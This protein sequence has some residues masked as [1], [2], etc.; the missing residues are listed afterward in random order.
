MQLLSM[1][2]VISV[3]MNNGLSSQAFDKSFIDYQ[4]SQ[5]IPVELAET[6][7]EMQCLHDCISKY[8]TANKS[9]CARSC[10]LGAVGSKK[11]PD[12]GIQYKKCLVDCKKNKACTKRCR[13]ERVKC[14]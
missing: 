11:K 9:S 14:I 2:F 12:C 1:F 13:T 6:Q 3:L 10:G 5:V 4:G 7:V 8:G